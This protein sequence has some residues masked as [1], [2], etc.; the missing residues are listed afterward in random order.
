MFDFIELCLI[1][2]NYVSTANIQEVMEFYNLCHKRFETDFRFCATN[3]QYA[4]ETE[5][6]Q[7][8]GKCVTQN[9]NSVWKMINTSY[10]NHL[11]LFTQ[12]QLSI[13]KRVIKTEKTSESENILNLV[14]VS[15][16]CRKIRETTG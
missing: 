4:Q 14:V 7:P 8:S 10:R 1:L 16:L 6:A 11:I 2:L 13:Y 5:N 12:K 9:F 3:V 15:R